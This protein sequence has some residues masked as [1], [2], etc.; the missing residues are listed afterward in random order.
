MVYVRGHAR[1]YDTWVEMGAD[2][3][4]Y[5]D[6]LPYFRRMEH[7]HGGSGPEFRGTDGPLHITRGPRAN[8]LFDAF[9]AAGE[10]AGYPVTT[11]YNG[12]QQEGFGPMEA[13]I[14]KSRR[15]SAANAYLKPALA[16]GN[17]QVVRG[18]ARRVVMEGKRAVG[19][20]VDTR[21]GR[22]VIK[23]GAR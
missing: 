10:Q 23:A 20:E 16:G 8:P 1:D 3:W 22:Q 12:Q 18:L 9:I 7:S 15:W 19:V 5:A 14:W 11:D 13:T 17:V 21:A 4:S 6:V 2:G